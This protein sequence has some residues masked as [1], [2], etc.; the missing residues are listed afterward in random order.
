MA[1]DMVRHV[2]RRATVATLTGA[3]G[4]RR[5]PARYRPRVRCRHAQTKRS[6]TKA[7]HAKTEAA[8]ANFLICALAFLRC[9]M[10]PTLDISCLPGSSSV[11]RIKAS[12]ACVSAM[13]PCMR[14][15]PTPDL[16]DILPTTPANAPRCQYRILPSH[17]R[18][19]SLSTDAT[20]FP[21]RPSKRLG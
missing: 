6:K 13:L 8:N 15:V 19:A 18:E 3:A 11:I 12:I 5:V 9:E 14:L 2:C 16:I 1:P 20:S 4:G 10:T 21:P 7:V 17:R